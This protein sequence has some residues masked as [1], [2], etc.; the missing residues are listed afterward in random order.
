MSPPH[1]HVVGL[2]YGGTT[3]CALITVPR[4]SIFGKEPGEIWDHQVWEMKGTEPQQVY[5]LARRIREI[6]SLDFRIGPAVVGEAWT[7]Q[8]QVATTDPAS[9]SPVRLA[10]MIQYAWFLGQLGHDVK[11]P[12]EQDR[13]MAKKTATDDRLRAWGLYTVGSDHERDAT[14][15]AITILRRAKSSPELRARLWADPNRPRDASEHRAE[16]LQTY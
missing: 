11:R 6:Q 9:L 2:D 1:L 13:A 12:V 5:L 14:R 8:P 3:G 10:A 15:Q 7:I 4:A 16:R